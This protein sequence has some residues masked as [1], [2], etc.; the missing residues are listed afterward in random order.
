MFT[1]CSSGDDSR[2][3]VRPSALP[4]RPALPGKIPYSDPDPDNPTPTTPTPTKKKGPD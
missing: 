3:P 1:F 4:V 2:P